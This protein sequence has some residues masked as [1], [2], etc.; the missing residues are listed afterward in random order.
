MGIG[1]GLSFVLSSLL[2]QNIIF[3]PCVIAIGVSG[4]KLYKSIIKNRNKDNIKI[5]LL[6]HTFFSLVM[7]IALCIAGFIEIVVSTN[8]LKKIIKYF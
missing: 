1:K 5:E 7:L 6:R 8:F 2:L 4:F 3:I